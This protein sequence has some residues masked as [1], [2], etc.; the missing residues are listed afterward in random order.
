MSRAQ[1]EVRLFFIALQF[2]TRIPIPHWVGF[3]PAWLI[4]ANRYLPAVGLVVG[5]VAALVYAAAAWLFPQPVA[6]LL[7]MAASIFVTGAF[8]EDG[9]ADT[10]DGFGGGTT[11]ERVLEIMKDSRI[12]SYGA[13][14]V[15]LV[16]ALKAVSLAYMP[17]LTAIMALIV[18]HAL[19]RMAA[20][21]LI[22][23]LQYV[24]IEGKAKPI[25]VDPGNTGFAIALASVVLVCAMA[26]V[27]G[28]MSVM[29]VIAGVFSAIMVTLWMSRLFLR[30]IGGYTG[31]CLGAVQQ[32]SEL[33][34]YLTILGTIS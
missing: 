4:Q 24:R 27:S 18:A 3:E 23:R 25:A 26:A 10:C 30:R 8:H 7:S 21:A 2:Y 20:L 1:H 22:R 34:F 31:D 13:I 29:M 15:F 32:V 17:P 5:A 33:I 28:G 11:Q 16:L 9:L 6:V 12:G 19:S 14:A